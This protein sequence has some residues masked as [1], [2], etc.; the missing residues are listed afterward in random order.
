MGAWRLLATASVLTALLAAPPV[1]AAGRK[2]SRPRPTP[3]PRPLY[4]PPAP[5]PAPLQRAAGSCIGYE[6][7]QFLLLAEVGELGRVF[8]IDPE[9]RLEV[10]PRRGA[11]IRV[12]YV[13]TPEGPVARDVLPGP[14]D[15]TKD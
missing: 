5:K 7:G 3:T 9:T 15:E 2:K 12:L 8:R 11:R 4:G 6:P 10:E 14:V 13:E 1:G